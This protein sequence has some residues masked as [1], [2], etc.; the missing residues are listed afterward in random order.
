MANNF[1][2]V[3]A[4]MLER[5]KDKKVSLIGYVTSVASNSQSFEVRAVDDVV[6][7]VNLKR[8]L[9][10]PLSGYVMVLRS[11]NI[12]INFHYK[13]FVLGPWNVSRQNNEL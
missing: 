6:V 2:Y 5:F 13:S 3:N 4:E 11:L 9:T 8:P 10:H 12:I 1:E 7:K